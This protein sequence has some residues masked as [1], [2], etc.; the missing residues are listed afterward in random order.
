L[1]M[2]MCGQMWVAGLAAGQERDEEVVANLA[3][4]RALFCVT[5]D[6]IVVATVHTP[7]TSADSGAR[8]P[9]VVELSGGRIA[10]LL[11]AVEWVLP[12][13]GKDPVRL[14]AELP[15]LM[16]GAAVETPKSAEMEMATDIEAIGI[17]LLERLREVA[18]NLHRKIDL[19]P[20]EPL[21]ELLL[22]G[23]APNYG[24]EVWRL[25][26]RMVQDPLKGDFWR[27]RILRPQSVQLY[28]PG[29]GQ[30]R[31]IL[32][33][34][35]PP[36]ATGPSLAELLMSSDPRVARIRTGDAA[37]GRAVERI[38]AGESHKSETGPASE[39]LRAALTAV[40][41]QESPLV[42]GVISERRG[43][44]WALA[45]PEPAEKVQQPSEPGAPTLRKKRP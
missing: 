36:D 40:V 26:Y 7:A 35:Y 5:K 34:F 19:R 45:P 39:F 41:A 37:M 30:P 28:P 12:A 29:K 23:N 21:L 2:A 27:T 1:T 16:G 25:S 24:P 44:E 17:R 32:E 4:G 14:D 11:G 31:T 9:A 13:S 22:A 18:A 10:I 8:A 43:V 38:A 42:F 6:G 3:T 15:R 20:D 33:V